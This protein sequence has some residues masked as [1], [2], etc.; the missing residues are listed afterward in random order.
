MP[1]V[2][3]H[4]KY[5]WYSPPL[6]PKVVRTMLPILP[7]AFSEIEYPSQPTLPEYMVTML[8]TQS[9]GGPLEDSP[10][11]GPYA[12]LSAIQ[13]ALLPGGNLQSHNVHHHHHL[14]PHCQR[15]W[16]LQGHR[17]LALKPIYIALVLPSLCTLHI[18]TA[19]QRALS[20]FAFRA[21]R[22]TPPHGAGGSPRPH[23]KRELTTCN[24]LPV[25]SSKLSTIS[26]SSTRAHAER[27]AAKW[28]HMLYGGLWLPP[29]SGASGSSTCWV[30]CWLCQL[31]PH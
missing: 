26:Q 12:S 10:H 29:S 1:T 7:V 23:D 28:Y 9:H 13:R 15:C 14:L 21:I 6:C 27:I 25:P 22:K 5:M 17:V 11:P 31:Y 2:L 19:S 18:D 4:P 30:S 3:V 8:W 24:T 20:I 16:V